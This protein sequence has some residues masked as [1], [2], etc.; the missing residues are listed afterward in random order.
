MTA[1]SE[2]VTTNFVVGPN[3]TFSMSAPVVANPTVTLTWSSVEGGTY[4]VESSPDLVN[5][6]TNILAMASQGISTQTNFNSGASAGF[7]RVART[8]LAAYDPV[9]T[10]SASGGQTIT[11]T[12]SSGSRGQNNISISAVISASAYRRHRRTRAR[13]WHRS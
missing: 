1:I 12:P 2:T 10:N 3:G 4:Q 6:T 11:V 13:R 8:A 5:W 9:S 7:Y